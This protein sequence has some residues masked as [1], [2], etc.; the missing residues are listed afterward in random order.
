MTR[1]RLLL[2]IGVLVVIALAAWLYLRQGREKVAID[3]VQEFPT[4]TERKP[5]PDAF[6]VIDATIGGQTKKAI[7][8]SGKDLAGTRVKW[9]VTIPENAWLNVS[10]ALLEQAWTMQG[11]GV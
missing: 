4:A 2:V 5:S 3:L 10:P 6:S 11:D 7:Y 8:I 9:H 1:T